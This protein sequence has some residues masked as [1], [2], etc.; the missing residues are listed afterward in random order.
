M[1]GPFAESLADGSVQVPESIAVLECTIQV[2]VAST[3]TGWQYRSQAIKAGAPLVFQTD[4][5]IMRGV[6]RSV[7]RVGSDAAAR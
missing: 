5:Y 6:I 1:T 7:A 4:R 2:P 3:E